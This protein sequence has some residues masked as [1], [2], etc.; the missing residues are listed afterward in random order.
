MD[1]TGEHD[2]KRKKMGYYKSEN[3]RKQNNKKYNVN[4]QGIEA[5]KK[6]RVENEIVDQIN[7]VRLSKKLYLPL[8]LVGATGRSRTD[9][10]DKKDIKV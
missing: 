7:H 2:A 3:K 4:V 8:E 6:Q 5:C 1:R 9:S 10:F